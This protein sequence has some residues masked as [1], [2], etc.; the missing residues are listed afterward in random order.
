MMSHSETVQRHSG[1]ENTRNSL[2]QK[3]ND[4]AKTKER[5]DKNENSSETVQ[6]EASTQAELESDS[7]SLDD[8]K[9]LDSPPSKRVCHVQIN[10]TNM[11][12][13][14]E[15]EPETDESLNAEGSY[16]NVKETVENSSSLMMK[17]G[18]L[19][20]QHLKAS[21]S[22][23]TQALQSDP[24]VQ[25]S[26]TTF[27][28]NITCVKSDGS[29]S[30]SSSG[31]SSTPQYVVVKGYTC[32]S[33]DGNTVQPTLVNVAV[34]KDSLMKMFAS[35][36]PAGD[37][38]GLQLLSGD[39]ESSSD[40]GE[41]H[42]E[43]I[44]QASIIPLHDMADLTAIGEPH[45]GITDDANSNQLEIENQE[46]PSNRDSGLVELCDFGAEQSEV[47]SSKDSGF[48]STP[49]FELGESSHSNSSV[50]SSKNGNSSHDKGSTHK[51][52]I[53]SHSHSPEGEQSL[54]EGNQA[55]HSSFSHN[56]ESV[57]DM[58][59]VSKEE[60]KNKPSLMVKHL[61]SSQS[62]AISYKTLSLTDISGRASRKSSSKAA[63]LTDQNINS[64]PCEITDNTPEVKI[65]LSE[66]SLSVT[67]DEPPMFHISDERSLSIQ[68]RFSD[69]PLGDLF[70]DSFVEDS[71]NSQ[72][73]LAITNSVESKEDIEINVCVKTE[74][75]MDSGQS[76]M[77]KGDGDCDSNLK[78][79]EQG[80]EKP[81]PKQKG[82]SKRRASSSPAVDS[83][84]VR[85]GKRVRKALV[86]VSM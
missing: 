31:S 32:L 51:N 60:A 85:T 41:E 82:P 81:T 18:D 13:T 59:F 34:D 63:A 28:E 2:S 23:S 77:A 43:R 9:D 38:M 10:D 86:K 68:P 3:S 4:Q 61:P 76:S 46:S 35:L 69:A 29:V 17:E 67:V 58:S 1:Q 27:T 73:E 53:V 20:L 54:I 19:S 7:E 79:K 30:T 25:L 65:S 70:T 16:D 84:L 62:S 72:P 14:K 74:Q 12:K 15:A 11:Q 22:L 48:D 66:D 50:L 78:K 56:E 47:L 37:G 75:T 83:T 80:P 21:L 36:G 45:P 64:P 52:S 71:S 57:G 42:G 24:V 8:S 5:V 44:A 33:E 40:T 39:L 6:C 49:T 55:V 26:P